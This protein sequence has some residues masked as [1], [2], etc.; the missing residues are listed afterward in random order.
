MTTVIQ[1][2]KKAPQPLQA[3]GILEI[4]SILIGAILFCLLIALFQSTQ[5][6]HLVDTNNI[7]AMRLIK[8]FLGVPVALIA[9]GMYR[10]SSKNNLP[11]PFMEITIIGCAWFAIGLAYATF[12]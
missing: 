1:G 4:V 5:Y 7:Y 12:F 9:V 11:S 3:L 6:Q 10:W 2:K 8:S